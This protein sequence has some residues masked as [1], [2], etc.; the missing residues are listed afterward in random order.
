MYLNFSVSTIYSTMAQ[1]TW[2]QKAHAQTLGMARQ[3]LNKS[4]AGKFITALRND[5]NSHFIDAN[6]N[7]K[8]S[9]V[10]SGNEC[11]D[12]SRVNLSEPMETGM[13]DGGSPE[14]VALALEYWSHGE[15]P[16]ADHSDQ[17]KQ[18]SDGPN[19]AEQKALQ[20]FAAALQEAQRIAVQLEG[21][22]TR[23]CKKHQRVNR[24]T[25]GQHS[26]AMKRPKM[27]P[28]G[29]DIHP[30]WVKLSPRH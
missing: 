10:S 8:V 16:T 5:V 6:P 26:T 23:K 13:D 20:Q 4:R 15:D 19:L 2:A 18:A 17:S 14:M 30:M 28:H 7:S 25:Q 11:N 22:Q 1:K 29:R 9:H 24:A 21:D 27:L 3:K 12:T